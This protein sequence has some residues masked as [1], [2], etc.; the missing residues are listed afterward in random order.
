LLRIIGDEQMSATRALPH[1][2]DTADAIRTRACPN[3]YLCETRGV[4]LYEGLSDRLFGA[5]GTWNLKRCANPA[6][7]LLWLDPMP[8]EDDIGKAYAEYYTH[9][10]T[11]PNLPNRSKSTLVISILRRVRDLLF[12]ATSI[13]RER[14]R[15]ALMYLDGVPPGRVL[16][17]GCGDGSRLARLRSL[18]WDVRGQEMDTKAA[19]RARQTYGVQVRLG[20][21]DEAGFDEGEF[22]RIIMNHVIEHV[23]DPV[24]LFAESVRLLKKGGTLIAVTPNAESC[25]HR[26]FGS[27][28]RGLEPPRHIHLFNQRTLRQLAVRA[29]FGHFDTWTTPAHA[30]VLAYG[31]LDVRAGGNSLVD[32]G[33]ELMRSL[34]SLQCQLQWQL[35]H[36]KDK[37]SGE[38][39]VLKAVK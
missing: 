24:R 33:R 16:D 8:V 26:R 35:A 5:P 19:S 18:G 2:E 12:R 32:L 10:S 30:E 3:C 11:T 23:H 22:D 6:C 13:H 34:F 9:V 36:R 4:L 20:P 25:G 1:T 15:L 37:N 28:W 31:S 39:C 27:S 17:V 38:E 14:K 29:D 21:L 7:G